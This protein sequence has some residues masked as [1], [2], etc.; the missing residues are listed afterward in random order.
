MSMRLNRKMHLI[1]DFLH[2]CLQK[3]AKEREQPL[4]INVLTTATVRET[5]GYILCKYTAL[6]RQPALKVDSP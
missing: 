6:G 4:D 5:I 1:D 3:D 2:L